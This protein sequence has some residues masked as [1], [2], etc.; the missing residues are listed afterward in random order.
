MQMLGRFL[1]MLCLVFKLPEPC[2]SINAS[3][4][5]ASIRLVLL[6]LR[7]THCACAHPTRVN[8]SGM[9][10]FHGKRER[11]KGREGGGD[12]ERE[13]ERERERERGGERVEE[14]D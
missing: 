3:L 7:S 12:R 11:E 10:E 6:V 1:F 8:Y 9:Q 2:S 13:I 14:I 4:S 5:P